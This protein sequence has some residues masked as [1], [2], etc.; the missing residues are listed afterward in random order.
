M[1]LEIKEIEN[2]IYHKCSLS[3]DE[4]LK[5]IKILKT[6]DKSSKIYI[7]RLISRIGDQ[8]DLKY[9]LDLLSIKDPGLSLI[10]AVAV[11]GNSAVE[12]IKKIL[13]DRGKNNKYIRENIIRVFVFLCK[14]LKRDEVSDYFITYLDDN[15][16]GVRKACIHGFEKLNLIESVDKIQNLI[17]KENDV[18]VK[19]YAVEVFNK[20]KPNSNL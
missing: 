7:A 20:L 9:I 1:E 3:E 16:S 18:G 14:Y 2:K 8:N 6:G 10:E 13:A 12:S 19:K 11:Y 4:H 5:L 17:E 15:Y